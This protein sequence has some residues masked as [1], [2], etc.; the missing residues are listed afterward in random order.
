KSLSWPVPST[1]SWP[2]VLDANTAGL[3]QRPSSETSWISRQPCLSKNV[4]SLS[5][6]TNALTILTLS[7]LD[8]PTLRLLCTGSPGKNSSSSFP[9]PSPSSTINLSCFPA[10]WKSRLAVSHTET[11]THFTKKPTDRAH[12]K[13]QPACGSSSSN[14]KSPR[15]TPRGKV[16]WW[17]SRDV[18]ENCA[19]EA[20]T[21]RIC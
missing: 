3:R 9:K 18:R 2:S 10:L 14:K 11:H 15:V 5:Y 13:C 19:S 20:Q 12:V 1:G 7:L 4:E 8:W 21:Q 16:G 6:S 17:K